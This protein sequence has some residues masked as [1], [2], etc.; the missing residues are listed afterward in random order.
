MERKDEDILYAI[1]LFVYSVAFIIAL[2][3]GLN[4]VKKQKDAN[5]GSAIKMLF[6][7]SLALMLFCQIFA[8]IATITYFTTHAIPEQTV[9][10][11]QGSAGSLFYLILLVTLVLRLHI[12]FEESIYKMTT[13]TVYMF[14][15][16]FIV[17][18]I[19]VIIGSIGNQL[20]YSDSEQTEIIGRYMALVFYL[21]YWPLYFIGSIA[22]VRYFVSNLSKLAKL[23]A[24]SL[25]DVT[26]KKE[27]ISL[28][29]T[30]QRMVNV[31]AKYILL[32]FVAI[33]FTL[34]TIIVTAVGTIDPSLYVILGMVWTLDFCLNF[35]CLYLQFS[36]AAEHYHRLCG[37][38]DKISRELV[39]QRTKR[40]IHREA[41]SRGNMS[42]LP[43]K[44][45]S[46]TQSGH[47]EV[48]SG[49]E[50]KTQK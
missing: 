20:R 43:P 37:C 2:V 28:D 35:I 25:R 21:V 48:L 13:R 41:I 36:F 18:I 23:R 7:V 27:D 6:F 17:C 26:L 16:L 40:E 24:N 8:V 1:C 3:V 45:P 30:Q 39:S 4:F 32:F 42:N 34:F 22:A 50:V 49:S 19:A 46:S 29:S 47:M 44:I 9:T 10:G 14:S 33:V 38:L 15:I 11:I 31:S 5:S 12:T